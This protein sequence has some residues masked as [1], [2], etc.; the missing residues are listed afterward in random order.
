LKKNRKTNRPPFASPPPAAAVPFRP[1]RKLF[2]ALCAIFVLWI[3]FL[4]ILY[5]TTIRQSSRS[6]VSTTADHNPRADR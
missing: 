2:Y 4:L 1:R 3:I 6:P 5:F